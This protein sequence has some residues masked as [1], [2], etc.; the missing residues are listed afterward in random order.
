[1]DTVRNNTELV[2]TEEDLEALFNN[3]TQT[4]AFNHLPYLYSFT[5]SQYKTQLTVNNLL[6]RYTTEPTGLISSDN[7]GQLSA[8]YVLNS[9]GIYNVIPGSQQYIIG[10]PQFDKAVITLS[11]NKKFTILNSGASITRSNIYIQGL[12]LDKSGYTK[13]YLNYADIAKGGEF[14]VFTGTMPNKLFMQDLEKPT[15]KVVE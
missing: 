11:N 5:K 12:N 7:Q 10:L 8:W 3:H 15:L 13:L 2:K 1:M 4:K 6:K 9:L 14:E